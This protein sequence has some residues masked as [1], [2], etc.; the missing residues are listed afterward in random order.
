MLL[1]D[2]TYWSNR[3][4]ATPVPETQSTSTSRTSVWDDYTYTENI[5]W[6]SRQLLPW[7]GIALCIF[8]ALGMLGAFLNHL[9]GNDYQAPDVR[10][11]NYR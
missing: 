2:H 9:S 4:S 11:L 8:I 7:I 3:A 6:L 5:L 10:E 1:V